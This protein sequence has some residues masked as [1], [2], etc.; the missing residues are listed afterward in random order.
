VYGS[1]NMKGGVV[2]NN[3]ASGH[4]GAVTVMATGEMILAG[5]TI[6]NNTSKLDGG[7]I[8][9]QGTG[10]L[11][12]TG[13]T[14]T[15]NAGRSGG[16]IILNYSGSTS[17]TLA[18]SGGAIQNNTATSNGGAVFVHAKGTLTMTGGSITGN[19]ANNGGAIYLHNNNTNGAGS[20]QMSAGTISGNTA[21]SNGGGVGMAAAANALTMTGGSISDNSAAGNGKD[22]QVV[23]TLSMTGSAQAGSV[24][25]AAGKTVNLAGALSERSEKTE[26]TMPAYTDGTAVLSGDA[27]VIAQNY[28]CFTTPAGSG[29]DI[30]TTG[31]LKSNSEVIDYTAR[32]Q[33][34]DGSYEGYMTLQAAIEAAAT[35]GSQTRIELMKDVT[36]T[37]S[38]DI[39]EKGNRNILLTDD[40]KGPH[41]ITRGFTA[42]R[43]IILR[44]G[45]QLTLEGSSKND[46]AP[47]LILDGADMAAGSNQQIIC[48]GTS[49]TNKNA[50]LTINAG[51][52]L[53]NNNNTNGGGAA[54]VYGTINMNGGVIDKNKSTNDHG[55]AIYI[56]TGGEM[57]L[58][59][60]IISNNSSKNDGGAILVMALINISSILL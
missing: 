19:S 22:I 46:S 1:L 10:K 9:V 50:T 38:L 43:M 37:T 29:V 44:T 30:D 8:I 53:A 56:M 27:S 16:A 28:T 35:D 5:G 6:S 60:G 25:L 47:S 39:P 13:G 14:I 45:N 55:G 18:M 2:D 41:T 3:K 40:G 52:K 57:T 24:Y 51:V 23:G 48:V 15:G 7:A 58:S 20:M 54:I 4:G 34:S 42:G 21:K 31:H 17:G 49:A 33:K 32:I 11:T 12:M 59:G 26:V 36:L